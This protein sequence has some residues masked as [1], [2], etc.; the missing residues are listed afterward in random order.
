[1]VLPTGQHERGGHHYQLH[2]L[3]CLGFCEKSKPE[4]VKAYAV[5][6]KVL[7]PLGSPEAIPKCPSSG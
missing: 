7:D 3:P 4:D 6:M 1:M 2:N 5:A